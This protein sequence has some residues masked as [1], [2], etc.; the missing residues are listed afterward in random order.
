MYRNKTKIKDSKLQGVVLMEG[1]S[2]EVKVRRIL[3]NKEPITDGAPVIYTERKDGVLPGYNI[4][5][6]RF[7]VALEGMDAVSRSH[8]AKREARIIEMNKKAE[9][10]KAEGGEVT[11][12]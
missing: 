3:S 10:S 9:S 8:I 5:T 2:I 12:G 1:E 4:K 6:D 11:G 7:E